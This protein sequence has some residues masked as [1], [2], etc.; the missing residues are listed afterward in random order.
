MFAQFLQAALR[1]SAEERYRAE[2]VV[3]SVTVCLALIATMIVAPRL[4][5]APVQMPKALDGALEALPAGTV[6]FDEY[7]LGGWLMWRHPSLR[8]VVDPRT[9]LYDLAYFKRYLAARQA[10]PGWQAFIDQTES[11][12]ALVPTSSAL[13]Q[14]VKDVRGWREIDRG[15][16]Y[17][18]LEAP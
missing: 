6:V 2:Q 17:L 8:P 12:A 11:R 13:G 18:L 4:A 16:G 15:D 14:A 3:M 1:R 10:E 9:E 7:Q 5:R